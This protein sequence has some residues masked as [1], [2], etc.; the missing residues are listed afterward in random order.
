MAV[1]AKVLKIAV[2]E[3]HIWVAH[4]AAREVE[5]VMDNLARLPMAALTQS[6]VELDA[7]RDIR[8]PTGKPRL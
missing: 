4:V 6:A 8:A 7:Q 5:L 1:L 2:V 3:R